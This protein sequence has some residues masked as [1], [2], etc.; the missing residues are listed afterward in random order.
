M[1]LFKRKK[2]TILEVYEFLQYH[3]KTLNILFI[4]F[5]FINKKKTNIF[6]VNFLLYKIIVF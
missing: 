1:E 2:K 4:Q 5:K 6:I 3:L